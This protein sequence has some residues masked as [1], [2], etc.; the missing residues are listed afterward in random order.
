MPPDNSVKLKIVSQP[1]YRERSGSMVECLTQDRRVAG[2]SLS[3]V[4][5]LCP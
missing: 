3:G 2:L 4:T 5:A 1:K